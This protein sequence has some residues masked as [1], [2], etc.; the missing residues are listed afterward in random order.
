MK[1]GRLY[2]LST[3]IQ[4][5]G[6]IDFGEASLKGISGKHVGR[7]Q[8]AV[9]NDKGGEDLYNL[10]LFADGSFHF[11]AEY[12]GTGNSR[13]VAGI[14]LY[15]SDTAADLMYLVMNGSVDIRKPASIT[16]NSDGTL[17][18]KHGDAEIPFQ[19]AQP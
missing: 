6:D 1:R 17:L 11:Y 14:C 12:Q 5:N 18:M 10:E 3:P 19:A 8:A 4:E 2:R 16:V 7:Y 9:A 15:Q 13:D